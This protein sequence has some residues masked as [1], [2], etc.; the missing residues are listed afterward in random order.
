MARKLRKHSTAFIGLGVFLF[1]FFFPVLFMD[2][3]VSPNDVF[4]DFDPWAMYKPASIVNVQNR[5]M[6]DPATGYLPMIAMVKRGLDTLHWNPYLAS[7]IP[8]FGS[9]AA[10]SFTPFVLI[11]ILLVPLTWS[12][13]AIIFLKLTASF[14]FAYLWLR[15]ERLG[16]RA[17]AVGAIIIAAAGVYSVRWLWQMTNATALYPALFWIVR[18]AFHGKRTSI[19][20]IT[21]IALSYAYSGFPAAMAY[22]AYLIAAYAIFLALRFRRIPVQ[23]LSKGALGVV[24]AL[25]IAAPSLVPFA[26][27]VKRT[28]YLTA[29]ELASFLHFYPLS[30]LRGF[31]DP[32][33]LGNPTR[34][35]TG[36][37]ALGILNNYF[38][39]TIY[40]GLVALAL[41]AF[42]IPNR[43]AQTRW[44]WLTAGVVILGTIFGVP[45]L[46]GII[47][48][49]PGFKYSALGRVVILLPLAAGYLSAAGSAWLFRR[50]PRG[51]IR[52]VAAGAIVMV[53]AWDLGTFAGR[54]YPYL[55]RRD[56][57]VPNTPTIQYLQ[58]QPG[59]F[60]VAPFFNYFWPNAAELFAIEDV[61]SHFSSEASYRAIL[62]RIDKNARLRGSTVLE[63]NSLTFNF[64]DPLVGMLGIRYLIEHRA[65]DIVKWSIFQ[66]TVPETK[67]VGA[68]DVLPGQVLQRTIRVTDQPFYS[69]ELPMSAEPVRGEKPLLNVSL[70]K[71]GLVA[72]SRD[73]T[74]DDISVMNK[75]YVPLR[76]YARNGEEVTVRLTPA[77]MRLS[78][79]LADSANAGDSK[80]FYGRV[81]TPVMFD[82]E[83]PDG[84]LFLNL[85]EL[86]RFR[87]AEK[88][89]RMTP[90]QFMATSVDFENEA[91]LTDPRTPLAA[92]APATLDVIDSAP[93]EQVISTSAAKPFF[94]ASSEKLTPEL[95]IAIDGEAAPAVPINLMFAGVQVPAGKH[96]VVFSR[97]IARG[98]WWLAIAAAVVLLVTT[99]MEER[100]RFSRWE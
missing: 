65:I 97:R 57:G 31:I 78:M 39:A 28:G 68:L 62:E 20:V 50:M 21:L 58:S 9:A 69:I 92:T 66:A 53:A 26:Q 24:V 35:W 61:R 87:V 64:K 25:A 94:L 55:E 74:P 22:G 11:P 70:L 85:G 42:S 30:H 1:V 54:F 41:F 71:F 96:E 95:R 86:P 19:V 2:R 40:V 7:G 34:I 3:V 45:P 90:D 56:A 14:W 17:A 83:L 5:L 81:T 100:G 15:E 8:G 37:A 75:I 13:T 91:V 89:R 43:R 59:P 67:W 32:E 46:A 72:W 12:Y 77:G 27:L 88:L 10:A 49:L 98:W 82:R 52:A 80:F 93:A 4:Y 48:S 47:G 18:R 51:V 73:F 16:K 99:A 79:G 38:E 44:F 84:R 76:P 60:R 29:R 36:S 63:L 6:N 23:T 33:Y